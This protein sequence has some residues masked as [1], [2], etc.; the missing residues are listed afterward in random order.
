MKS[1][2]TAVR[3]CQENWCKTLMNSLKVNLI[4]S[5]SKQKFLKEK[6]RV[7]PNLAVF[8][9]FVPDVWKIKNEFCFSISSVRT[10]QAEL[11]WMT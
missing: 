9:K 11:P 8:C 7:R 4:K 1:L 3:K 6:K 5:N 2:K 10:L